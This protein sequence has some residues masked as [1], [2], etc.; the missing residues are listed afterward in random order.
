MPVQIDLE[1]VKPELIVFELEL[2]E[3]S[4]IVPVRIVLH[5]LH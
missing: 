4:A 3:L 2:V 5:Y 1:V